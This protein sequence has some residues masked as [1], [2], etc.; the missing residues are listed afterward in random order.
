MTAEAESVHIC[1]VP[2]RTLFTRL[3]INKAGP[4]LACFALLDSAVR[5]FA[6]GGTKNSLEFHPKFRLKIVW[7]VIHV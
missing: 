2:G 4:K 7:V 3:K 6:C 1:R 5:D